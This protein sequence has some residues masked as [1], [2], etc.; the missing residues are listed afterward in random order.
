[1]KPLSTL[2]FLLLS[3]VA[4]GQGFASSPSDW[5]LPA[6]GYVEGGVTY[7]YNASG[8]TAMSFHDTGSETWGLSDMDGD[9]RTDLVVCGQ[10]NANGYVQEFSPGSNSYWKVYLNNGS[11]FS[12]SATNW[13]LPAGGYI[14]GGVTYG[15]NALGATAMSFHDTGSETWSISDMDGDARPDLVVCAQRNAN[16]YVQEFSP[17]S[18]SYWKVY[19]N[20]GSGFS[21]SATNW[22]LPSGGYI[23]GG[24][25]YGYNALGGTAMSFYDTGSETWSIS[26][27]DGDTRPDLVVSAQ[28][29]ANGYVQEFSP[30][31][32][33]YWK[34][35]LNSGSGFGGS[36]TNWSLPAGGYIEGGVTYG[37]NALGGTAMS[38]YDT[39]SETWSILDMNSDARPDLV[40]PA[41]RNANGYVQEFSPGS[42]SYWKVYLNNGSGFS[43]SASNW[44][45]PAGGNIEGG[46][47]YGYNALGGTAMSFYDTGSETWAVADMDHDGGLDL[48]VCAQ[49]NANGY[50]QEFSPGSNSYWKVYH[51]PSFLAVEE[52]RGTIDL[53]VGPNP[54]HDEIIVRST[55][56]LDE[57]SLLDATGKTLRTMRPSNSRTLLD[58]HDLHPGIYLLRATA[59][60]STTV[61]R[62]IVAHTN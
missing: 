17:G 46:V 30:G 58:V 24:V 28:R 34:V 61:R 40:V 21:S 37:Y 43:A 60:P 7:G 1:M 25:T 42:N 13:S 18:N 33:S 23:E 14:E 35:Y 44:S 11:G 16:G 31:S 55:E 45:L 8:G 12:A 15:Y 59:G 54:A 26:D 32:N 51:G 6:G 57:L 38:F 47:T 56:P 49:R 5:S 53:L 9:G 62:L 22:P 41:Q 39:G 19:A 20:N 48:V 27:M 52:Q 3:A 2:P 50:V 36:A 10:R 29:N 4:Y